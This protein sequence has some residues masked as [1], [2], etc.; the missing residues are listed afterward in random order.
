MGEDSGSE[1]ILGMA[2]DA[3]ESDKSA[4]AGTLVLSATEMN[5][6]GP[7]NLIDADLIAT[8]GLIEARSGSVEDGLI[9]IYSAY[10]QHRAEGN[11]RRM[12][13]D[14]LNMS[15]LFGKL[16]RD[17]AERACLMRAIRLFEQA[18]APHSHRRAQEQLNRL[19]RLGS[20]LSFDSRRN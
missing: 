6:G 5:D 8:M 20:V 3:L 4:L 12:G 10:R 13:T 1:E 7:L 16:N 11:F 14:Q 18:P 19:D 9:A 2:N 17:R 15:L